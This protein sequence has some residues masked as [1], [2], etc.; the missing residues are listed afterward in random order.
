MSTIQL[1]DVEKTYG[2]FVACANIDLS[3]REGEFVTILGPSGSGK[4]TLLTLIAGL[5]APTS[6]QILIG[7]RDVTFE[8]SG[9]RNVG[10]VFQN[11]A[12][13][14]HLSVYDNIAFPLTVRRLSTEDTRLRVTEALEKVRLTGFEKRRPAQLSGGQQQRVALARAFVFQPS[15]LLLD[16]PLGALDRKLREQVQVE[17]RQLQKSLGITTVLVTHDQE[18]A[19]SLSDRLIVLDQGHIQQI[20]TPEDAYLRPANLFVADFLGTANVFQG[21]VQ[22]RG[23]QHRLQVSDGI[24]V[25]CPPPTRQSRDARL[26]VR[27]E[28]IVLKA[29]GDHEALRATVIDVIYLGQSVRY[30][31]DGVHGAPLVAIVPGNQARFSPGEAVSLDWRPE[32]SWF[33]P[34]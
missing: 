27:P 5:S 17:L 12:L 19:L 13:F 25:S 18:E 6:G 14:P 34:G 29:G 9:K 16:E 8:P 24:S 10:L 2:S 21:E 28:N 32:D 31:L 23:D 3:V 22:S 30:Q 15:I 26:I 33:V 11:Y 4:T 1:V 20:G 7:G